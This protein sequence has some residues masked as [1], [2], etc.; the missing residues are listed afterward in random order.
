[1]DMYL[2]E[3]QRKHKRYVALTQEA[4]AY[5]TGYSWPGNLNQLR[6]LCQRVVLLADKRH[7]NDLFLRQQLEQRDP[8]P[9]ADAGPPVYQDQEARR[10]AELLIKHKGSRQAVAEELGISKTTLWRRMKRLGLGG[11]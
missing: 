1:M 2:E 11:E 6:G 10:L 8:E 5:L 9:R 7:V 3:Y 4:R